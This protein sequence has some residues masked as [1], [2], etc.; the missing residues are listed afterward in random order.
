MRQWLFRLQSRAKPPAEPAVC[1][2]AILAPSCPDY[3]QRD[4]G[5]NTIRCTMAD[6]VDLGR[7]RSFGAW[8]SSLRDARRLS[9]LA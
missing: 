8:L 5:H 6:V 9:R 1:D 7:W 2:Y 3:W 4:T